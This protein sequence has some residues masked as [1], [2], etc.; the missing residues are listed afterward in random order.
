M[1]HLRKIHPMPQDNKDIEMVHNND[2]PA[3]VQESK[4]IIENLMNEIIGD[5]L[6]K[7]ESVDNFHAIINV[8]EFS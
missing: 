6:M 3:Q 1:L 5:V 4:N 8:K 2:N 7:T